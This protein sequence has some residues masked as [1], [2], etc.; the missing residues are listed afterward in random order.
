MFHIISYD[1]TDN[2]MR[3]KMCRLLKD[4]GARVQYSV[5]ECELEPAELTEMLKKAA[6]FLNGTD[7]SLR[8]YSLCQSCCNTALKLEHTRLNRRGN[9]S[10][11]TLQISKGTDNQPGFFVV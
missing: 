4:Y 7:D 6:P 10:V 9:A 11:K 5:F 8:V 1:I 2:K 3:N